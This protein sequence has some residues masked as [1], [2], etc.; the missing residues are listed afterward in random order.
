MDRLEPLA[1]EMEVGAS[2]R[3]VARAPVWRIPV[4]A[5][6]R[7]PVLMTVILSPALL[8]V[9]LIVPLS[10]RVPLLTLSVMVL[11]EASVVVAV[12][13]AFWLVDVTAPPLRLRTPEA[14]PASLLSVRVPVPE[15]SALSAMAP[16]A[17][18]VAA[19]APVPSPVMPTIRE[20]A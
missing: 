4:P 11:L 1:K 15:A 7:V 10:V 17:V 16:V 20:G 8:R 14:E 19:R 6:D 3:V 13:V 9:E 18:T 5:R 12:I 2:K